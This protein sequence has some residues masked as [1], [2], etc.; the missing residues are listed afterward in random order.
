MAAVDAY[1]P[2]GNARFIYSPKTGWT[3]I[4]LT[5]EF[6]WREH[7]NMPEGTRLFTVFRDPIERF[8]SSY[9]EVLGKNNAF[10]C[11]TITQEAYHD[12][13]AKL[14]SE[15]YGSVRSFDLYIE[16]LND[17]GIFDNHQMPQYDCYFDAGKGRQDLNLGNLHFLDFSNIEKEVPA[18]LNQESK[19]LPK[20]RVGTKL[21]ESDSIKKYVIDN[22]LETIQ[23][24]YYK[25]FALQ[26]I[27]KETWSQNRNILSIEEIDYLKNLSYK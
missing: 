17:I 22:K 5:F 11:D 23:H 8:F 20:R 25:D 15:V 13:L 19:R 9:K 24:L 27:L 14:N 12:I 10:P 18:F 2:S 1:F 3:S 6:E 4:R 26:K 16:I 7:N 21:P